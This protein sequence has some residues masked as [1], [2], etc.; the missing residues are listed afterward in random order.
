MQEFIAPEFKFAIEGI[1]DSYRFDELEKRRELTNREIIERG[2]AAV[3][4]IVFG[5]TALAITLDRLI[6]RR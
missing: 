3:K 5:S 4:L 6:N 1:L 2:V